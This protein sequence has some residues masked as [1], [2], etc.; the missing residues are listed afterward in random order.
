M[1]RGYKNG[2][3]ILDKPI[4]WVTTKRRRHGIDR[5]V[6]TVPDQA[7]NDVGAERCRNMRACFYIRGEQVKLHE[8]NDMQG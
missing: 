6:T 8:G 2:I 7:R 4:F 5:N 1:I 3:Y